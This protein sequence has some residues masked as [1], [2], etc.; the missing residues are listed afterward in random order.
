MIRVVVLLQEYMNKLIKIDY[1]DKGK[2]NNEK[3]MDNID[4]LNGDYSHSWALCR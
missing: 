3:E 1:Y 2:E 4:D